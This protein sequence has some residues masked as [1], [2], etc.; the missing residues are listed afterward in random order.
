MKQS[1]WAANRFLA[2]Q[3]IPHILWNPKVHYRIHKS[4][5]PVRILNQTCPVHD[6][7]LLED[8]FSYHPP[9]HVCFFQVVSFPQNSAPKPRMAPVL[10]P[11]RA[12]CQVLICPPESYLLRRTDQCSWATRSSSE[13]FYAAWGSFVSPHCTVPSIRSASSRAGL[14]LRSMR[15][16]TVI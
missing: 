9:I 6:I 2:S 10:S 11:I 8:P 4:S 15:Y 5:P 16:V 1:P 7:A 14:G 13:S 3:E 12:T